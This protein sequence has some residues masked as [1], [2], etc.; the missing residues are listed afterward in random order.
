MMLSFCFSDDG[1]KSP[2][3]TEPDSSATDNDE[4]KELITIDVGGCEIKSGF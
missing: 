1:R 2:Q 4:I 3:S